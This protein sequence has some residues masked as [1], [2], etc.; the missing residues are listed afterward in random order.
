MTTKNT[1]NRPIKATVTTFEII[2]AL[3]ERKRVGVVELADHLDLAP[4]TVHSHLSTLASLEYVVQRQ[5]KYCLGMKF[6]QHG[7]SARKNLG[8]FEVGESEVDHLAEKTEQTAW[9]CTE[10]YG[11]CA[12]IYKS[13]GN[14]APGI[15]SQV[16]WR[17]PLHSTATGKAILARMSEKRVNEI[18]D[19]HGLERRTNNT[20]TSES[21]LFD[22]LAAIRERGYAINDG[23][24]HERLQSVAASIVHDEQ[25]IGAVSVTGPSL[26]ASDERFDSIVEA[27][28]ETSNQIELLLRY[29]EM[30]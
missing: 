8:L 28:R 2:E 26:F 20:V 3:E 25:L 22:E 16:G 9:L 12:V 29:D 23:E 24:N 27:L 6:L 18:I 21:D 4:S 14:N 19:Q 10:E 15:S 1:P 5:G 11:R 30:K 17:L 7:I 13:T